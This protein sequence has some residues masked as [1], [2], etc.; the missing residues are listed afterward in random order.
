VSL[1]QSLG[2]AVRVSPPLPRRT[3]GVVPGVRREPDAI[4]V[5]FPPDA[6][7]GRYEVT[8]TATDGRS[9]N[10]SFSHVRP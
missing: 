2:D 6:P 1:P 8:L 4:V 10:A 5:F 3:D 7:S 9:V